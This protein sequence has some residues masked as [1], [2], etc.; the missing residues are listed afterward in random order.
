MLIAQ[1]ALDMVARIR[2]NQPSSAE[3]LV[4]DADR[5]DAACTRV[6]VLGEAVVKIDKLFQTAEDTRANR[7]TRWLARQYPEHDDLLGS[8]TGT[9]NVTG[10]TRTIM[11]HGE[12]GAAVGGYLDPATAS[13]ECLA[14]HQQ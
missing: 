10:D 13:A 5:W 1:N 4:S 12:S 6:Q 14:A 11:R 7:V 9:R 3:E 8:L 2:A